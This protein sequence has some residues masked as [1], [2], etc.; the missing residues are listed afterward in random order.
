MFQEAFRRI[1]LE[2]TELSKEMITAYK[3]MYAGDT[4]RRYLYYRKA[5]S[6]I[7]MSDSLRTELNLVTDIHTLRYRIPKQVAEMIALCTISDTAAMRLQLQGAGFGHYLSPQAGLPDSLLD[8]YNPSLQI[9]TV[10]MLKADIAAI[11]HAVAREIYDEGSSGCTIRF[12]SHFAMALM[13]TPVVYTGDWVDGALLMAQ[14]V[15]NNTE[16]I[17]AMTVN[18]Q[19]VKTVNSVGGFGWTAGAPGTKPV[20]ARVELTNSGGGKV[21]YTSKASYRVEQPGVFLSIDNNRTLYVGEPNPI[22]VVTPV[23]PTEY[24]RLRTNN[25]TVSG[26]NGKFHI[27]PTHTG[28]LKITVA[29]HIP[30]NNYRDIDSIMCNAINR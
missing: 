15:D 5:M 18:G 21:Y 27:T 7:A 9:A 11:A 4:E 14:T 13:K 30:G 24:L 19:P 28:S 25:G 8:Y 26:G 17:T 6:V 2:K 29:S 3:E 23:I 12:D 22:T 20:A 16:R 10:A 1:E